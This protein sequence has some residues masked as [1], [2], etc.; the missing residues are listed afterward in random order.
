MKT[1]T[2]LGL[3]LGSLWLCSLLYL[4]GNFFPPEDGTLTSQELDHL[5]R[6]L[7]R[8]RRQNDDLRR[9][10]AELRQVL[11]IDVSIYMSAFLVTL[12]L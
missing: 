3:V 11:Q 1:S 12:L 6:E 4:G 8:I 7:H 9:H 5:S 10:A 2:K